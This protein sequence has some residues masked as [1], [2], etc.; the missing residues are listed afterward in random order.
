[1]K[2]IIRQLCLQFVMLFVVSTVFAAAGTNV[3]ININSAVPLE[4][5]G[6]NGRIGWDKGNQGTIEAVG[7]GLPPANAFSAAQARMLARRAAVVDAYRNLAE[8]VQGVQVDSE[9]TMQNLAISN[10]LVKTKVSGLVKGARIIREIP[11]SDGSYQVV[12]SINMYGAGSLA[13]IAM[14]AVK[15]Q[16]VQE[17]PVPSLDSKKNTAVVPGVTQS[18]VTV[19][20]GV[21]V[22]ARGLELEPTFSPRIYDESGRIVY[23][24]MYINADFAISQGMVEYTINQEMYDSAINGGA[25]AGVRPIIVKAVAVKDNNCNVVISNAD[26]DKILVSNTTSG[27]LKNC[28]VVFAR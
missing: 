13:E 20:T 18:A 24:N 2:K 25:R 6:Q 28:A 8:T 9:T 4:E 12:M 17:F 7:T 1:M 19:Y 14:D 10:D 22:D 15:P 5:T 16:Q 11:Q 27:F 26:A 23:G 21:I 3:N